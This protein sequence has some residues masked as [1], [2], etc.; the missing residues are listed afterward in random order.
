MADN[1]SKWLG[2]PNFTWARQWGCG[3]NNSN[4]SKKKFG[5]ASMRKM[6]KGRVRFNPN[7][8]S[9]NSPA[10]LILKQSKLDKERFQNSPRQTIYYKSSLAGLVPNGKG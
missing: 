9:S 2:G 8:T 4:D 1:F 7:P 3:K 6:H 10:C 5:D